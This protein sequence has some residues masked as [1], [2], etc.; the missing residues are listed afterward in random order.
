MDGPT[1]AATAVDIGLEHLD[2][3]VGEV[4]NPYP[5]FER[6]RRESPVV[7]QGSVGDNAPPMFVV[8]RHADVTKVLRDGA[9][10]S[11][12][13][14]GEGMAEVWGRKII[15][16]MDAPE[17]HR[18][19]ALVSSAFRQST[20][21]RWKES[22]VRRIVDDLIDTFIDR[23]TAELTSQYTFSFPA[24][25]IAGVLGLP[26]AD[27]VQF[28][29]W[30]IGIMSLTRD[31][32][33]AVQCAQ[34]L[35]DYLSHIVEQRR[36]DPRDD[37]VTDLV[38]VE[39][40]GERLDDEEIYSFLRMLLPAGIE[41][42]YRS[43]GNLLYLLL[44]HPDQLGA[45]RADR[46]LIPQAIE[47]ALRYEPPVLATWRVTTTDTSIAEVDVPAGSVVMSMLGSANRDPDVYDHP[48]EFDI[49]RDPKQHVSFGT[50]PHLCLGMHLARLETAIAV[51]ALLDRLPDVRLDQ[52]EAQRVDAHIH[53]DLMF[54]SP[55]HL[56]VVW[57]PP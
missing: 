22:L 23:G 7:R 51:E 8:Y 16:G 36:V 15:V 35:R 25:V 34:E 13:L 32:N 12:S 37:L 28:Q 19:R 43:S 54:R 38:T 14:I 9:T 5:E 56:P 47:E 52:D 17:H 46:T 48:E 30:A 20:L 21:A 4:R 42:T 45:V 39:L 50:G 33:R 55:N 11:S 2:D 6:L 3:T 27:Y 41:T 29:H 53:G 10:F 18:H 40:D 49:F 57:D 26:E 44:T 1:A 31:W 24:K